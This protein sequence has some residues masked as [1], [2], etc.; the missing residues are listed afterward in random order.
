[1]RVLPL[2]GL[3]LVAIGL[4]LVLYYD[5]VIAL[6][7]GGAPNAQVVPGGGLT[8]IGANGTLPSG[9]HTQGQGGGVICA[10]NG[11]GGPGST[12]EYLT[13]TGVAFCG[14]GL[15]MAAVDSL[16]TPGGRRSETV[17]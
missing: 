7:T 16:S 4:G 14:A 15:V 8:H 3:A 9:C 1:M 6:A 12:A 11:A 17:A 2:A 5:P 13:V 10:D